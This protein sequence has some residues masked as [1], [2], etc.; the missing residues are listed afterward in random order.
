M[1]PDDERHG[2]RRGYLQHKKDGEQPCDPCR[3]AHER[4]CKRYRLK[5][6]NGERSMRAPKDDALAILDEAKRRGITPHALA[7]A[8][9]VS[10]SAVVRIQRRRAVNASTVIRLR[11]ALYDPETTS[12]RIPADL[13][14]RRINGLQRQGWTLGELDKVTGHAIS[15]GKWRKQKTITRPLAEAVRD[16]VRKIGDRRGPSRLAAMQAER[17]GHEVLAA[18][19]DPDTLAWPNGVAAPRLRRQVTKLGRDLDESRIERV[20]GGEVNLPTTKAEKVEIMRRWL[21]AGGSEKALC[22]RLGWRPGRYSREA[23]EAS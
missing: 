15:S 14:R 13:T 23:R 22:E 6:R 1:R 20:L 11:T 7:K 5:T 19:D 21:A 12:F 9:G 3:E 4:Y 10:S 2:E 17:A 18:W 16:A 8:A